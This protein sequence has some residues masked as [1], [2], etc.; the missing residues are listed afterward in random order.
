MKNTRILA[1]HLLNDRSGSPF[2]FRQALETLA[3][4]GMKIELFTSSPD[5]DGFLSAIPNVRYHKIN[6]RW[7]PNR[8]LTLFFFIL[9]QVRLFLQILFYARKSDTVYVNSLLP[10]GAAIAGKLRGCRVYYHVHEV[11]LKPALLKKWL[12][13][14]ANRT[15]SKGFFVSRDLKSR[16]DFYPNYQIIP[17]ALPVEFLVKAHQSLP[18]YTETPFTV[19]MLCSLKAYKG[20]NEF[21]QCA[22]RL[23]RYKFNLV[24]NATQPE[25]DAYFE[26]KMLPSNL[27]LFTAQ[28][29]VHP[30]Y[31]SADVVVNLSHTDGWIETFGMT[32]LEAM[33]YRKPVIVPPVGGISELV[34]DEVEGFLVD[35]KNMD[36]LCERLQMLAGLPLMYRRMSVAAFYRSL[37]YSTTQFSQSI[38]ESFEEDE[39][40]DL[41]RVVQLNLF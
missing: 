18:R 9:T 11:S 8:W 30:F 15:A 12:V 34:K 27:H 29:N 36:L 6:Y 40:D 35:S 16:L 17:N 1:V 2:V 5:G 32:V 31:Q 23:P 21:V 37:Q 26:G 22:G 20:V 28:T 7:H 33:S 4:D 14:V 41:R 24:L 13:W 39:N 3:G 25:I 19:L 10:F 38:R